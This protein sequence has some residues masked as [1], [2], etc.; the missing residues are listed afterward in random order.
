MEVSVRRR[1]ARTK[2]AWPIPRRR[3]FAENI[4]VYAID[5]NTGQR[6]AQF[7]TGYD[8]NYYFDLPA[9]PKQATTG[10]I[11]AKN[12]TVTVSAGAFGQFKGLAGNDIGVTFQLD[13]SITGAQASYDFS[14]NT[15]NVKVKDESVAWGTIKNAIESILGGA[16]FTVAVG[17]STAKF[18]AD[19]VNISA[20]LTGGDKGS[21]TLGVEDPLGRTA[22]AGGRNY[23]SEW[24]IT[25]DADDQFTREAGEIDPI[26]GKLHLFNDLNF[27]LDPGSVPPSDVVFT[28][29]VVGD[30]N[31]NGVQDPKDVGVYKFTVY[32]DL[33]HTGQF[34]LGEPFTLTD[35]N[36]LYELHVPTATPNTFSITV[37]PLAGWTPTSPASGVIN[38]YAQPGELVENFKFLVQA[39]QLADKH[40]Q[41]HDLR[42]RIRR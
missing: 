6:V 4:T 17:S 9:N 29:Q 28:G 37:K 34:E 27:L 35:E 8:G 30:L 21:Y 12:T 26:S 39:A 36:G 42:L 3:R 11:A 14:S 20:T 1:S 32:A 31:G 18:S 23:D 22:L 41:R 15:I 25:V 2:S 16:Q 38:E 10:P 40:R 33:N 24:V 7:V 13:S 19:D 5:N